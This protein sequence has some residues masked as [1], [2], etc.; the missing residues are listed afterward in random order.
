MYLAPLNYDR[1]F[2]K[3]FSDT[4]IAKSFLEDFLN[5]K[6]TSIEQ[7]E[8]KHRV[9]QDA[10]ASSKRS[11][12]PAD[13]ATIVEFDY[14]C[15]IKDKY[16]IIDMQQWYK[17]DVVKRFYLYHS[18]NTGL[19]LEILGTKYIVDQSELKS[20]KKSRK[21]MIGWNLYIH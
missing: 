16:I 1:F 14:R 10:W 4:E 18:L 8:D 11:L 3:I 20:E 7:L 12:R 2:K 15:K 13:D 17:P 9:S 21:T 19:Q 5:E 6:I